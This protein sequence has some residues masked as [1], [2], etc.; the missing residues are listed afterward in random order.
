M[1]AH[2]QMAA[3]QG[4]TTAPVHLATLDMTVNLGQ[5][6]VIPTLVNTKAPVLMAICP[7][8]NALQE[9][10]EQTVGLSVSI[11]GSQFGWSCPNH[12]KIPSRNVSC[13][14]VIQTCL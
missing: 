10:L 8:V 13:L 6:N 14:T 5:M 12:R 7:P 11:S 3:P 1:V 4:S 2:A 9:P